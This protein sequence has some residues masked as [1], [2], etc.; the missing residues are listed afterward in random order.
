M[1]VCKETSFYIE[2]I[3]CC[4]M[5]KVQMAVWVYKNKSNESVDL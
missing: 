5:V 1:T 2:E 3:F 4:S